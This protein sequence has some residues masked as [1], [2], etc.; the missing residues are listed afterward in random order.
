MK[1][2]K[3]VLKELEYDI[4]IAPGLLAKMGQYLARI[5][6]EESAVVVSDENVWRL[7]GSAFSDVLKDA[8]LNFGT[9][10]LPPG[11]NTKSLD[12]LAQVYSAFAGQKLRRNGLVVAFGGGVVGDL[13]GF[14][15][16]TWMRGAKYVQVPT[17]LL[18]QVDSS[19]G[20]KTAID[21]PGGKNLVGAFHHPGLV[22]ADTKLL[23]TL[24]KK[25]FAC[26]MAEVI[27]YGAISSKELFNQLESREKASIIMDDIIE[28]CCGIKRDIVQR[29]PVEKGERMLL[30][31][32]HTLGHAV[33]AQGQYSRFNHGQAVAVGMVL[34]AQIG[35]KIG[36]TP[37][38]CHSA[39]QK[40]LQK[41]NL[42][43]A[44]PYSAEQMMHHVALDK[45][46]TAGGVNMVLLKDIGTAKIVPLPLLDIGKLLEE[47]I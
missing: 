2:V 38:G 36:F 28:T 17:S 20:G 37:Q 27:K 24:P 22:L 30:N 44:C 23:N 9:V 25:Q 39:L 16:A 18:A 45:K 32:G 40:T 14:A 26:G 31:F 42:E 21:L 1:T 34:A 19:V 6:Q 29:D 46:S 33:E 13:A 47:I 7:Y 35:Q 43:T 10:V 41:W 11:E 12:G 8:G 4:L 3:V 5:A 15:A